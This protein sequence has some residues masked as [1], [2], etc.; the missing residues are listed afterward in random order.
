MI[1]LGRSVIL[2]LVDFTMV[3]FH[4]ENKLLITVLLL[5][6]CSDR[7][8]S[9]MNSKFELKENNWKTSS[10]KLSNGGEIMIY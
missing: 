2:H 10:I 8:R 4:I 1:F 6:I 9:S 7:D 3:T 5:R